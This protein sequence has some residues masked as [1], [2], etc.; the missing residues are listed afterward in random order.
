MAP[1]ANDNFSN[2]QGPLSTSLPASAAG[3]TF[4]AT[5]ESGEPLF[6]GWSDEQSV[7]YYFIP[8]STGWYKFWLDPAD[9]TFHNGQSLV[10]AL[11]AASTLAGYTQTASD[12]F[13]THADG[14]FWTGFSTVAGFLTSGTTYRLR[15]S[16][17]R[18]GTINAKAI[19]Y[20]L[21]WDTFTPPSNDDF[22]NA[23]TLT[24]GTPVSWDTYNATS[25]ASEPSP[26]P[27][28]TAVQGIWYKFNVTTPGIHRV[29]IPIADFDPTG[30][31]LT[32]VIG[33]IT[34][35]PGFIYAQVFK[36]FV[37]TLAE[38]TT[39][40][41]IETS[42]MASNN[43]Q[44]IVLSLNLT[45]TGFYYVRISTPYII[46]NTQ[47][48]ENY[49]FNDM[50]ASGTILAEVNTPPAN[51]NLANATVL[52]PD[53]GSLLGEST[54]DS[55]IESGE[56][57]CFFNSGFRQS[58]WYKITPTTT[59]TYVFRVPYATTVYHGLPSFSASWGEIQLGLFAQTTLANMTSGN[60]LDSDDIF[61]VG[62]GWSSPHDGVLI[63]ELT[64]GTT[65]H[66]KV[67]GAAPRPNQ[68]TCDYDFIWEARPP[69]TNDDF[70]NA[71]AISG[72][73]GTVFP[74]LAA[75]NTV[76][77]SEPPSYYWNGEP[78]IGGTV[79]FDWTCPTTGDYVFKIQ[80]TED[81]SGSLFP[82]FDLAVW[83][84][85]SLGSLTKVTR[86]FQ[87]SQNT[88]GRLWAH[89]TSVGFHAISGQHYKIQIR[90]SSEAYDQAKLTW[91]T[92]TVTGDSTAAPASFPNGRVDN[93]GNDASEPPPNYATILGGHD[94]WWF[95]DG[96]VGHVKWFKKVFTDTETIT[97][98]GNFWEPLV[99]NSVT[100]VNSVD[101]GLIVY[102]GANYAS[103]TPA[104]ISGT[105]VDA[106][107]M[108]GNGYFTGDIRGT[109][110]SRF[111]SL[112]TPASG[113]D[114]LDFMPVDVA[115]GDT[116]WICIFG[117]YDNDTWVDS[118]TDA[119]DATQF[120][121]DLHVPTNAPANDIWQ[122]VWD[123]DEYPYTLNYDLYEQNFYVNPE[124]GSRQGT[125]VGA[126][127]DVGE[128]SRAGF[129]ATRSVWYFWAWSDSDTRTWE[130]SIDSPGD[131]VLGIYD[132]TNFGGALGSLL[133]SDDD[134]GPG[135]N[136]LINFVPAD[137][138]QISDWGWAIVVDSKAETSFTLN[139]RR[140]NPATP[141]ANDDFADAVVISS[142]PFS[143]SGTTVGATAEF[144]EHSAVELSQGPKDSVWYKYVATFT[145]HLKVKA[146]C[147]TY[148]DDASVYV[149][150]WKGTTLANLVRNPEPPP[151][152]PGG[153][154]NKG[155][156]GT[157]DTDFDIEH[158]AFT[159]DVT[160]GQTY[161][162][163]VQTYSGGS[164]DFI[165]Y[166]EEAPVYLDLRPSG[167]DEMHGTLIDAAE[168]YLDL[169]V[170]SVEV[171]HP[172]LTTDAAT[173]LLD[174]QASGV[175]VKAFQYV[176]SGTARLVV[177][178][179]VET[180][181]Y[182]HLEPSF[183]ADGV[184]K[185]QYDGQRKWSADG[186]RRWTWTEGEGLPQ[187]C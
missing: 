12:T 90:N 140:L 108:F 19:D 132:I 184:R 95:V 183:T 7:W 32:G 79:W 141:P 100:M 85:S 158:E 136:P 63:A 44:D 20:T 88:E 15:I 147:L 173:V 43:T 160:S 58:V 27:L 80:S 177:T 9:I 46:K 30:T 124:A 129:A 156:F 28:Y 65:Y 99:H 84:G 61:P 4:D 31:H 116:V 148:N 125:T 98:D 74:V 38:A 169:Q 152:G 181:C 176:D 143:Q 133:A 70:A 113:S 67:E 66:I 56:P 87:G 105:T 1:P 60:L 128:G 126:T 138:P 157:D 139:Y 78:Q 64:A 86:N 53:G 8:A 109:D 11:G 73:T 142:I 162:I 75:G 185:W 5:K 107:M 146:K 59:G 104:K 163:R 178:P 68:G 111:L 127:A 186:T 144:E 23:Q 50:S 103:L 149:D 21:R 54:Y 118:F 120:E 91:R 39:A 182:F 96:Q 13:T 164:E 33:G 17:G 42:S 51:D 25:E 151:S 71:Q 26:N 40:N 155:Y 6:A 102:K 45:T 119:E 134:S 154:W 175:D 122:D 52:D 81:S 14:Q 150:T 36:D 35:V 172:A 137:H 82:S 49:N 114:G 106:A 171:F 57:D 187:I 2:A 170:T 180:E 159:I 83:Q 97:I 29:V 115:G 55:T 135:S 161:Y 72:A 153:G 93:F 24:L 165:I 179:G 10:M 121:V 145:G 62:S 89:A 166:L 174:L 94:A 117:L 37:D 18:S 168:V 3:T 16:S 92:N 47:A 131:C 22:A 69:V 112:D 34:Q 130:F 48:T 167:S 123:N 77:A 41:V 110:R 76:E 101:V